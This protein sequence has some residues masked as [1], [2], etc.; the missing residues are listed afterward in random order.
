M[1]IFKFFYPFKTS[2]IIKIIYSYM[3][4]FMEINKR[5]LKHK[6]KLSWSTVHLFL[7]LLLLNR[8]LIYIAEHTSLYHTLKK[9]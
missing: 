6:N 1:K 9:N 7:L 2:L 5:W 4:D 8:M 3:V